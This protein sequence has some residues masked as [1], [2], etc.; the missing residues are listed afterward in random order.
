M[1][2][3]CDS[4]SI[5]TKVYH[6]CLTAR[7]FTTEKVHAQ[8]YYCW[9]TPA[10]V[11]LCMNSLPLNKH[12]APIIHCVCTECL[13]HLRPLHGS[14]VEKDT[15]QTS[16]YFLLNKLEL[17]HIIEIQSLEHLR[18]NALFF[19]HT[20]PGI[21]NLLAQCSHILPIAIIRE[22]EISFRAQNPE[23]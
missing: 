16:W 17:P 19:H 12:K 3:G 20:K 22:E 23:D 18:V 6:M 1:H 2:M 4:G 11:T 14:K 15:F 8:C 9:R 10:V 13:I 5:Y 21:Q 7:S